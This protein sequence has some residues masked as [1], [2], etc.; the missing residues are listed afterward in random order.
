MDVALDEDL[1]RV[2]ERGYQRP[3]NLSCRRCEAHAERAPL[4][5]W[6]HDDRKPEAGVDDV[7]RV[8]GPELLH[9][10][11]AEHERIGRRHVRRPQQLLGEHLVPG[12]RAGSRPRT[13]VAEAE[14]LEQLLHGAVLAVAA[15]Q[16][17]EHD[18]GRAITQPP[19][20]IVADVDARR[21]MAEPRQ[22]VLHARAG[23]ERDLAFERPAAGEHGDPQCSAHFAS[24]SRPGSPRRGSVRTSA[25]SG[26]GAGA[27]GSASDAC[28]VSRQCAVEPHLLSDDRSDPPNALADVVFARA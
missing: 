20:Q 6:L 28:R 7:E 8:S 24:R 25:S 14:G 22:G 5:G 19:D 27:G 18:I 17:H 11:L 2:A 15:V 21:R 26:S 3:G 16:H 9:R 13:G 23:H 1:L 10:A 4:A 12:E